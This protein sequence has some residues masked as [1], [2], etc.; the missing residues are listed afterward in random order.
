MIVLA[1]S[2]SDEHMLGLKEVTRVLD[3]EDSDTGVNLDKLQQCLCDQDVF[4]VIDEAL[5]KS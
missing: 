4:D 2:S 5:E 1:G 3:D